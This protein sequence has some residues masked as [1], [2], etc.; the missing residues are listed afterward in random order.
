MQVELKK[1]RTKRDHQNNN[2]NSNAELRR[3]QTNNSNKDN[4]QIL[5]SPETMTVMA[6]VT[7][8]ASLHIE[9]LSVG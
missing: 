4:D 6:I 7:V 5:S 2:S 9:H 1:E 3:H 8:V